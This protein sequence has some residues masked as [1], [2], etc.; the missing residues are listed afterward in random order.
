MKA[1]LPVGGTGRKLLPLT[2][3]T[4]KPLL[5]VGDRTALDHIL[6]EVIASG[7]REIAFVLK[8][9]ADDIRDYI[10]MSESPL[11][12]DLRMEFILQGEGWGMGDAIACAE[13]FAG[14]DR[15]AVVL[16]DDI[17]RSDVPGLEQMAIAFPEGNVLGCMRV[18][19][20]EAY[21][22]GIVIPSSDD[23]CSAA[24]VV[25]KPADHKG[26]GIAVAGRYI[27]EPSMFS[28][29]GDVLKERPT[30]SLTEAFGLAARRGDAV[31]HH[32]LE[33]R[34]YDIGSMEGYQRA[35]VDAVRQKW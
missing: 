32:I 9:R 7:C 35:F 29:L 13:G 22:Y 11:Y 18:P 2:A 28:H 8:H 4:L 16:G 20:A 33:G 10:Q 25:E 21:R 1:I 31:H 19:E 34:R 14:R 30:A 27:M 3:V 5:P 26:E 6:E 17:L 15:C 23:P 12:R 24:D